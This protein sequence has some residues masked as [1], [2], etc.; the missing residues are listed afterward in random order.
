MSN[1]RNVRGGLAAR[2]KI[3]SLLDDQPFS[4]TTVA[5]QSALSYGVV[6]YHLKLLKNEGIVERRGSGRYVWLSTGLGQKRLG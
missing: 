3:L 4:A 6:T 5:K 1:I 2:T